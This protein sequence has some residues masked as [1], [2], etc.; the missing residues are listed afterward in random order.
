MTTPQD[1]R[2]RRIPQLFDLEHANQAAAHRP[3]TMPWSALRVNL[4]ALVQFTVEDDAGMMIS[5]RPVARRR[6]RRRPRRSASAQTKTGQ[7]EPDQKSH[8]SVPFHRLLPTERVFPSR[9]RPSKKTWHP[10]ECGLTLDL[11]RCHHGHSETNSQFPLRLKRQLCRDDPT[12]CRAH[13][14]LE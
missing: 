2:L 10:L 6:R 9:G 14:Q 4:D 7:R 12:F 8:E 3:D 5:R 13:N 1:A 11:H